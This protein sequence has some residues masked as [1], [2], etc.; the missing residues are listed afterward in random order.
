[1]S[2]LRDWFRRR[3]SS[4]DGGSSG[5]PRPSY[6]QHPWQQPFQHDPAWA[7]VHGP[8]FPYWPAQPGQM[9]QQPMMQPVRRLSSQ[10]MEANQV[11]EGSGPAFVRSHACMHAVDAARSLLGRSGRGLACS[12]T[13]AMS[14]GQDAQAIL[15]PV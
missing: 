7:C 10:E 8:T 12:A 4:A 11:M 1:M 9:P 2:A 13:R 6:E 5:A 14:H 3:P 15:R